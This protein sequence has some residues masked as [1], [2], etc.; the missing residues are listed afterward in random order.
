MALHQAVQ[1]RTGLRI[2]EG[3][4]ADL[5]GAGVQ[6]VEV[7]LGPHNPFVGDIVAATS[8]GQ[9]Y[10]VSILA[11]RRKGRQTESAACIEPPAESELDR[12]FSL[13]RFSLD[14]WP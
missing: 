2:M 1:T 6:F 13:Q 4:A 9:H 12:R 11:I 10:G 14:R 3:S 8:F 7:V 5:A